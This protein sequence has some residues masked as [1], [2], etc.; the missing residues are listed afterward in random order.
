VDQQVNVIVLAI[1]LD[2]FRIHVP[3]D[4]CEDVAKVA[5]SKL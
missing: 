3:T 1:T 5:Y 4:F 2:Q